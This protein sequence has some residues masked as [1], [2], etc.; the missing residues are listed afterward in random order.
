MR[1]Q[2]VGAKV[3]IIMGETNGSPEAEIKFFGTRLPADLVA[4][5]KLEGVR[6]NAP[7]YRLV[8]EALDQYLP[9][10]FTLA[11]GVRL[12]ARK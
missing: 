5:L 7:L 3:N 10:G 9:K 6:R 1:K 8:F 4:R 2:A 12:E 11:N